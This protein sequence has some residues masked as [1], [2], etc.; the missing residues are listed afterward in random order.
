LVK[1]N[2][3]KLKYYKFLQKLRS[4]KLKEAKKNN[5][6]RVHW[7][8]NFTSIQYIRY[9]GD[10]L[11]F[12]WGTKDTCN[13]IKKLI[14]QFLKGNLALNLSTA[15]TKVTL[16][17]KKKVNFLGFQIWQPSHILLTTKKDLSPGGWIDR[18]KMETKFR[19]VTHS[20]QRIKVT[21]SMKKNF[22][23]TSR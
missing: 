9:A 2:K 17:T 4:N 5:I 8:G 6:R 16:L 20:R 3:G 13:K 10:F 7:N 23:S 14:S 22:K 15:K 19:G 12:V 18:S 11:I 1:K 21:F